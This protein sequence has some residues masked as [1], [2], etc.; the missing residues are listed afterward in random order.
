MLAY[1]SDELDL[2][3]REL[4]SWKIIEDASEI[5][6]INQDFLGM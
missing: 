5:L 1:S 6:P 2:E 3:L 4:N